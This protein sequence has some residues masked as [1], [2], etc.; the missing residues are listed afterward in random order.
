MVLS[1]DIDFK[2]KSAWWYEGYYILVK[3]NN[4]T[5]SDIYA[6]NI[7]ACIQFHKTNTYLSIY[8]K[9]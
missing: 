1:H 4:I 7:G 5:V 2:S 3:R 6:L 9:R 8:K